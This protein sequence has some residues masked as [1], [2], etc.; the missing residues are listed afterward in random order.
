MPP[1]RRRPSRPADARDAATRL[2]IAMLPTAS[3]KK[4]YAEPGMMM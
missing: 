3:G 1:V 4:I 2:P